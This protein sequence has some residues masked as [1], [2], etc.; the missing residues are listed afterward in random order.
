MRIER[1]L[2]QLASAAIRETTGQT[3][4]PL[5]RPTTD[6][7]HGDYQLNAAMALAKALGKKPREIAEPLAAK[8]AEHPAIARAEVAGPGF[9]NLHLDDTWLGERLTEAARDA[10]RCGIPLVDTPEK[11]VVDFSSPNIA[12]QMHVGHL[13]STIIGDAL[14]R[15]LR[16]I[17]HE[18]IGDNHLGDWGTQYGLLLVGMR[19]FGSLDALDEQPIE[20]LERVYKLASARAKDDEDFAERARTELA[21]LQSGDAENM[22]LWKKFVDTT[23][24]EL[25]R[26][27]ERMGIHF[28]EWLGESA[29]NDMLPGVVERLLAA[30]LAREDQGAVGV[31]WQELEGA[32]A[33]LA[34]QKEPFLVRKRD[35]AFLYST[36]DIAAVLYR[37][38]RWHADRSLYVVDA[39]QGLHFQQLFA[40]A[41]LLGVEMQLEHISFGTV[42][43]EAGKPLKT[44]DGKAVTLASLLDEAERRAEARIREG[45]AEKKLHIDEQDVPTVARA[46]GIGAVK[47]ADLRQNRSSDYQFDWDKLV[48]FNGNAGPYLQYAYARV[49]SIFAKGGED[50]D[51]AVGP[52][53]LREPPEERLGRVLARFGEVVHQAAESYLPHLLT[54][55]LYD[56]AKSFMSFYEALPVLKAEGDVRASRLALAALTA[57]QMRRGLDL[58]GIEVLERM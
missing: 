33:K 54:D 21:K 46:V 55:H 39:R 49:A 48:S 12:K 57:R 44:R 51:A 50:L 5:L 35:G 29:Y 27:Y 24:R 47:Y 43:D 45:I 6:P 32:P 23:R 36:T 37:K 15:L 41:Q 1:Y 42:L 7:R 18:V 25:E 38:D 10:E 13:R 40:V 53:V 9:V 30:G 52:I 31:F 56:L 17:G 19:E 34:K 14:C 3:S 2:D 11:I 16:A 4:S 26:T 20:E 28:D 58:L 8:L 22:A